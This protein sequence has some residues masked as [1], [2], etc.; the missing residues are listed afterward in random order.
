M[1]MVDLLRWFNHQDLCAPDTDGYQVKMGLAPIPSTQRLSLV[2]YLLFVGKR[3]AF[4]G[5]SMNHNKEPTVGCDFI[6]IY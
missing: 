2:I 1:M 3:Q 4:Y 5:I 6:I